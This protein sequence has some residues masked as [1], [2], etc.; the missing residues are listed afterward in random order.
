VHRFSSSLH[1]GVESV[2]LVDGVF[3]SSDGAIGFM[4]AVCTLDDVSVPGFPLALRVS[5]FVITDTVIEVVL[6][7]GLKS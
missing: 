1:H 3:H 4:Q 6:G 2:V 7:I 5:G